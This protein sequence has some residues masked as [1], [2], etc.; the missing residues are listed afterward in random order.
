MKIIDLAICVNNIDP[1]GI[2][3]IRCVRYNDYVSEKEKS[4]NYTDWSDTDPFVASPFLPVNINMIPKLGQVVKII[5]YDTSKETVNQE[6]IAGPFTTMYDFNS[7]SFTEQIENTTYGVVVKHKKDIRKSTGEFIEAKSENTFAKDDDYGLYG[8]YGS[9]IIFTNNGVQIRGGKLKTKENMTP[10]EKENSISFPLM[11]NKSSI[12][13]LKKYPKKGTLREVES[14]EETTTVGDLKTIIEYEIDSLSGDTTNIKFYV[15]NVLKQLPIFKTNNFTEHVEMS[16]ISNSLKLINV[17]N[18]STSPTFV[19]SGITYEDVHKEIRS[20]LLLLHS[21]N[22]KEI[23]TLYNGNDLHPFFY[24]PTKSFKNKI[25]SNN[26]ETQ[27]K[28]NIFQKVRL[29]SSG[30]FSGGLVWSV[31]NITP[32]STQKTKKIKLLFTDDSSEEQTISSLKSDKIYLISTDTNETSKKINFDDIDKYELTQ[33]DYISKIEPNTFS[34]VRG[35]NLVTIL[36][37]IVEVIFSHRHNINK[38]ISEQ[39]D[40]IQG[41]KL[42]KLITTLE[43]DILNKSIKIN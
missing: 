26:T 34:T 42:L 32:K 12:L 20:I 19:V 23:N 33:D 13:H 2:G 36:R 25:P 10:K 7:Q 9:D 11:S 6:Y 14:K 22:L 24:R 18:D 1:K 40:Y 28:N 15:Y 39:P 35:E 3:R 16:S 31:S 21:K 17:E 43:N 38:D 8:K 5:N 27:V 29:S 41:Q 4:V 37:S 30:P